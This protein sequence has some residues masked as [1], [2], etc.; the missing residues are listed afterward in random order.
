[1]RGQWWTRKTNVTEL[2][3]RQNDITWKK[4]S[5][6]EF[7]A[8]VK[9]LSADDE[10]II[11]CRL[12]QALNFGIDG[13]LGLFLTM[14]TREVMMKRRNDNTQLNVFRLGDFAT[15]RKKK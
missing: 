15:L 1:M 10:S 4:I 6:L 9:S 12:D 11:Q 5:H 8:P 7:E 14:P 3:S 13:C 2:L